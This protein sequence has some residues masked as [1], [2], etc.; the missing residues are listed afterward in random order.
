MLRALRAAGADPLVHVLPAGEPTK[1]LSS[2]IMLWDWLADHDVARRDVI[3]NLGGGVVADLGGWVAGTYM[4]GLPYVNVPTTLLAQVDGALGGKVA[5]NHPLAKNLSA[6]STSRPGSCRTSASSRRRVAGTWRAGL[7]EAIKKAMIASPPLWD[8]IEARADAI[9]RREPEPL[10]RLVRAASAIK[11]TL[12][13]RDPYEQDLRRPLNFGHTIGH[14]VETV[15]GYGVVLHGEAVAF[16]MVVESTI[17]AERGLLAARDLEALVDL[18]RRCDLPTCAQELRADVDGERL[19]AA[20]EKV[21]QI[22]AGSLR[23]V[24]PVAL[25]ETVIADDVGELRGHAG[26]SRPAG[27]GCAPQSSGDLISW[28]CSPLRS[29]RVP[30]HC[31]T[32][33]RDT[34]PAVS[35]RAGAGASRS[36]ASN[37]APGRICGT[38]KAGATSTSTPPTARSSSGT[39]TPP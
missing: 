5:V 32:R 24:L 25:G 4:R 20:L 21:R 38:S 8:F 19:V 12:I 13:A 11:T 29:R 26:H 35:T 27:S 10:A 33:P 28:P 1:S 6:A 39:R 18:L 2:A 14:P 36:S 34:S 3:V 15:T 31:S 22:R 17:A 7:A 9:L 30:R 16:G 37:G 23:Y